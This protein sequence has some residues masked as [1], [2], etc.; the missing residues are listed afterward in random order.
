MTRMLSEVVEIVV[1]RHANITKRKTKDALEN[2]LQLNA[3]AG[4]VMSSMK[5]YNSVF[6]QQ[7]AVS[8]HQLWVNSPV[9]LYSSNNERTIG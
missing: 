5:T 4:G 2:V 9:A 7:I 3:I 6:H 8:A 1:G